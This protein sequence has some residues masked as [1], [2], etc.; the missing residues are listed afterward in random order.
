MIDGA[1][2]GF[3]TVRK[4]ACFRELFGGANSIANGLCKEEQKT[5]TKLLK[6]ITVDVVGHSK[7]N[8]A[9]KYE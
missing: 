9:L 3:I 7:K 1:P 4:H 8:N 2:V 5:I 6:P